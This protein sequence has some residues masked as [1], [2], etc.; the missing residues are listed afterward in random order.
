MLYVCI[1][2]NRSYALVTAMEDF[3]GSRLVPVT[4]VFVPVAVVLAFEPASWVPRRR[5]LSAQLA[6]SS[7]TP[8]RHAFSKHP[9]VTTVGS[10]FASFML[11][12][13]TNADSQSP[14]LTCASIS[15]V[16]VNALCGA[17]TVASC[18]VKTKCQSCVGKLGGGIW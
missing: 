16:Y 17:V 18:F 3:V 12:N 8:I 5:S 15:A 4:E 10:T 13:V 11:S 1:C 6:F 14:P 7:A 9:N 2:C